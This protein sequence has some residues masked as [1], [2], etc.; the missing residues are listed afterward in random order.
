M[1]KTC[2]I[3]P[4]GVEHAVVSTRGLKWN[5]S[6]YSCDTSGQVDLLVQL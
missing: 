4:V 1:G 3:L 5:L 2:G 6:E